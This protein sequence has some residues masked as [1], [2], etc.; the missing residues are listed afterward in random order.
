MCKEIFITFSDCIQHL[1]NRR[2][3]TFVCRSGIL[4]DIREAVQLRLLNN[5]MK[6]FLLSYGIRTQYFEP[7]MGLV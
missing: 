5:E 7:S 1:K 3:D 2:D 6:S 4:Q